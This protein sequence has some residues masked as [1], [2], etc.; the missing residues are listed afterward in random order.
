VTK[1]S[2]Q[3]SAGP[4]ERFFNEAGDCLPPFT[5]L[6]WR[7]C[8][9]NRDRFDA[10]MMPR[11][12]FEAIMAATRTSSIDIHFYTPDEPPALGVAGT[13]AAFRG[14]VCRPKN[15]S[16][17]HVISDASG[18]WA[19]LC[20]LDV[21]V[22]GASPD[23]AGR[24]DKELKQHGTSLKQMTVWDY[25]ATL[26]EDPRYSYVRAVAGIDQPGAP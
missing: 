12:V 16:L 4:R 3:Q 20:E 6:S 8:V 21:V 18:T 5:D 11:F 10:T 1:P 14:V 13:W 2:A 17:E 26:S 22:V 9:L 25:P 23:V 19:V 24:I 15:Q 7:G